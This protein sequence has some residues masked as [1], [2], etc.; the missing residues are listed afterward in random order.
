MSVT[1]RLFISYS[2]NDRRLLE[3]LHKHLAQLKREGSIAAWYDREI[4]AGGNIENEITTELAAADIFIAALS[5]DFIA[6]SYCYDVELQHALE[7]EAAGNLTIV[8]VIFEP[9][10]WLHTE[11]GKFKAVPDDGKPVSEFTNEN[12]AF[13]TVVNE[14]RKLVSRPKNG[15]QKSSGMEALSKMD[16]SEIT[17]ANRYRVKKD[18]DALHKRDFVEKSFKE[19]FEFFRS[20]V[21][22]ISSVE[23]IETR[24]SDLNNDHFSCT[25][26]NRGMR[27]KYETLH[28]RMGGSISAISILYGDE[29]NSNS[30]NGGFVVKEGEYELGFSAS[31]FGYGNEKETLSAKDVAQKLWDDLLS[32]VGVDYG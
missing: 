2:H 19:I 12:V 3:R 21:A 24:L 11:L 26:I 6:S 20:S 14:L 5:P 31:L 7:R 15:A 28:I 18:F 22:E 9:C 25:I 30:S 8:P 32:H 27:R 10:D 16:A 23:E 1:H 17:S 13:L 4:S 29:N